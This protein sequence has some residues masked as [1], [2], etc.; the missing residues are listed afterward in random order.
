[1]TDAFSKDAA[2]SPEATRYA[3]LKY[4]WAM[5]RGIG[6][7]T[8]P[9]LVMAWA[10]RAWGASA[11]D[12]ALVAMYYEVIRKP[13]EGTA[14]AALKAKG[15]ACGFVAYLFDVHPDRVASAVADDLERHHN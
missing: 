4:R 2:P 14:G 5:P 7:R 10:R 9:A 11:D 6:R 8:P 1:M 15:Q 12:A 13:L 3:L